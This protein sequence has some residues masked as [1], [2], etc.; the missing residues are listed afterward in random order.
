[1]LVFWGQIQN[2]MMRVSLRKGAILR[3]C[4]IVQIA[5]Y[6]KVLLCEILYSKFTTKI[7]T[8]YSTG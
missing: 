4:S 3:S 8:F 5:W 6:C 7:A 2:Y 1:M